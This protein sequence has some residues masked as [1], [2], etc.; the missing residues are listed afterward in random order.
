[1][2]MRQSTEFPRFFHVKVDLGSRGRF[3]LSALTRKSGHDV[4]APLAFG[5]HA[6]VPDGFG[7]ILSFST[8]RCTGILYSTSLFSCSDTLQLFFATVGGASDQFLLAFYDD[9]EGD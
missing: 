9:F 3:R 4:H 7:S 1:M 5:I 8:R 6:S 2:P